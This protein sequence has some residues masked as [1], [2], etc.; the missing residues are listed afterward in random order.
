MFVVSEDVLAEPI[1]PGTM[2]PAVPGSLRLDVRTGRCE[3][4]DPQTNFYAKKQPL[5]SMTAQM[6]QQAILSHKELKI[7]YDSQVMG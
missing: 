5:S 2:I 3:S 1:I 4:Y 7:V 6:W